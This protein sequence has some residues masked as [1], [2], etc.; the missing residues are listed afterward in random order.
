MSAMQNAIVSKLS[1]HSVERTVEKLEQIL[2]SRHV[3]LFA[4]VDRSGEAEKVG[5]LRKPAR[6]LTFR[7]AASQHQVLPAGQ[8]DALDWPVKVL[9]WE[10]GVGRVWISYTNPPGLADEPEI[11]GARLQKLA[12]IDALAMQAAL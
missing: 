3:A 1:N 6:L 9:V 10:D 12:A 2:L 4:C 8:N 5:M 7:G 11:R